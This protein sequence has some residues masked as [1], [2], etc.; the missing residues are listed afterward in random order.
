M[1]E[2]L[3]VSVTGKDCPAAPFLFKFKLFSVS[4]YDQY[5]LK[6]LD[7]FY[8]LY[9]SIYCTINEIRLFLIGVESFATYEEYF[10][11]DFE[12]KLSKC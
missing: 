11:T 12:L 2:F 10:L 4:V 1:P 7:D 9:K 5:D 3:F 8:I 6:S